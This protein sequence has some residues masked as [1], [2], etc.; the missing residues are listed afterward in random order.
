MRSALRAAVRL[1]V[2][3]GALATCSRPSERLPVRGYS[4]DALDTLEAHASVL[5]STPDTANVRAY[6][7]AMSE[8]PHHAGSPGAGAVAE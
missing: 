4:T 1:A 3:A 5:R 2:I 6:M 7:R 8:E